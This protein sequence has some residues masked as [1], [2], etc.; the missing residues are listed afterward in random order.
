LCAYLCDWK[1]PETL[2]EGAM[3]GAIFETFVVTEIIKFHWHNGLNPSFYYYRDNL[4]VEIDMIIFQDGKLYPIEI[5][6]TGNPKKDM[7]NNF[8]KLGVLGDVGYGT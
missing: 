2:Q 6:K 4:Q 7:V 5:K 3:S 8:E 1:T